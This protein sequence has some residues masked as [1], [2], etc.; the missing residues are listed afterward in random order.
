MG[1][2]QFVAFKCLFEGS[3]HIAMKNCDFGEQCFKEAIARVEV[4]KKH[5]PF[6]KYIMPLTHFHLSTYYTDSNQYDLAKS[7]L[8]KAR[9]G[10]K[11]YELEDRIQTQI[12][13]LQRRIK[14]LHDDPKEKE[15]KEMTERKEKEAKETYEKNFFVK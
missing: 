2:K 13:S 4:E 9:D 10:Y 12:R 6:G 14:L 8:N 5:A 1:D 15:A 3:I 7:H 11:D